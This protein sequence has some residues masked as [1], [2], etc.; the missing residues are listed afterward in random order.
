M[1]KFLVVDPMCIMDKSDWLRV[2]DEADR[3]DNEH[4]PAN[5]SDG[6]AMDYCIACENYVMKAFF[7][8]L[9]PQVIAGTIFS[10]YMSYVAKLKAFSPISQLQ[11]TGLYMRTGYLV[12]KLTP[13]LKAYINNGTAKGLN[14][15]KIGAFKNQTATATNYLQLMLDNNIA[16]LITLPK[17]ASTIPADGETK[18]WNNEHLVAD[19]HINLAVA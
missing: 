7:D 18:D 2:D 19:A 9:S 15:A 12:A 14:L 13:Q 4:E 10:N 3:Y 5:L 11:G 1:A 16:Q 8:T 6:D 17:S